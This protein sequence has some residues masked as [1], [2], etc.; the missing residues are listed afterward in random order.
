MS[1]PTLTYS[2]AR[3]YI[4]GEFQENGSRS[5]P[6]ISPLDGSAI[7]SVA[8][9][10]KKALDKAVE[11]AGQA[12]KAWSSLTLKER[13][14]VFFRFRILLEEQKNELAELVRLENGKTLEE[15]EAEVLKGIELSE[16]A[17]SLP[18]II[19]DEVQEVSKGVECRTAHVPMG[20]VA[21]IT[22][23]N[24]PF[25]VPL[26]TIPNALS[27]GNCLIDDVGRKLGQPPDIGLAAAEVADGGDAA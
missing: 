27:L 1:I 19:S 15:A 24:F 13:V 23:F 20:V 4:A 11:S 2:E 7:S 9:S 18:Q 26:W 25:M 8:L 5:M 10:D 17:C 3:N 14:Q 22:P 16:F 12:F 6:V 21:S